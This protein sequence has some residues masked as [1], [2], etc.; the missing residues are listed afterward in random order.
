MTW[1]GHE[2]PYHAR[3]TTNALFWKPSGHSMVLQRRSHCAPP[4]GYVSPSSPLLL[5]LSSPVHVL[6][7][8]SCAGI[9]VEVAAAVRQGK[10]GAMAGAFP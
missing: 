3:R 9:A 2:G 6:L 4:K 5:W 8:L 7:M 10:C 1:E